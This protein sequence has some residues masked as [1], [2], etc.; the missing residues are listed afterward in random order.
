MIFEKRLFY[1]TKW[2][3]IETVKHRK[4]RHFT[5]HAFENARFQFMHRGKQQGGS[6]EAYN[7]I[8]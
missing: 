2:G 1:L 3:T 8:R 4:N 5:F 7:K 6:N